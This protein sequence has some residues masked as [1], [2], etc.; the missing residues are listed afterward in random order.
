MQAYVYDGPGSELFCPKPQNPKA[1][2]IKREELSVDLVKGQRVGFVQIQAV[3]QLV[4]FVEDIQCHQPLTDQH[5]LA[6]LVSVHS[7]TSISI[8]FL[9]KLSRGQD[10]SLVGLLPV[11]NQITHVSNHIAK[12]KN[13]HHH[14][15]GP[16]NPAKLCL[17]RQIPEAYCRKGDH[18][19][20][21][22]SRDVYRGTT[23][24]FA[25]VLLA[26]FDLRFPVR[27]GAILIEGEK[28]CPTG[29]DAQINEARLHKVGRCY[30]FK[31]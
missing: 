17:R 18:S 11:V 7:S 3:E 8:H 22:P 16:N 28:E 23:S 20:V 5:V 9:K 25:S 27:A 26:S 10:S 24:L 19:H 6:E 31:P 12:C 2:S 29:K 14:H 15:K 30:S 21:D 13:P 1:S 4:D